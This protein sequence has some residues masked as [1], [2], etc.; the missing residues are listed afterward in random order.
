MTLTLILATCRWPSVFTALVLN[1]PSLALI[2]PLTVVVSL[3]LTFLCLVAAPDAFAYLANPDASSFLP[4]SGGLT[5]AIIFTALLTILAMLA[6]RQLL[7][8]LFQVCAT[9]TSEEGSRRRGCALCTSK[10]GGSAAERH[11]R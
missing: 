11:Q 7:Y 5:I 4:S 8:Q 3:F 2:F 6:S 9:H 1:F 10:Q